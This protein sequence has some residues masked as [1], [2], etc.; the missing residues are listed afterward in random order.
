MRRIETNRTRG[1][2]YSF[3]GTPDSY[4]MTEIDTRDYRLMLAVVRA[5]VNLRTQPDNRHEYQYIS[6]L[7]TAVDNFNAKQVKK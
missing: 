6:D 2:D 7:A 4:D 1:T 3:D 5:A